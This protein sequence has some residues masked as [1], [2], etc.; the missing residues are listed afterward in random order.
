MSYN[1]RPND[2]ARTQEYRSERPVGEHKYRH[3]KPSSWTLVGVV[4]AATIVGGV[5]I[6]V[7][8]WP[9]FWVCVAIFVLSVPAGKIIGIMNDTSAVEGPVD[10]YNPPAEEQG[11]V[12]RPG[13]RMR[14][15]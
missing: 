5:A 8:L 11:T 3:G 10:E 4:L 14:T 12:A 1:Q 15:K 2:A 13:V 6:I 9:L 7:R